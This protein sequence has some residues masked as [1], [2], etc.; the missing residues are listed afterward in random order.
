[1]TR[2]LVLLLAEIEET[3]NTVEFMDT[4]G[5]VLGFSGKALILTKG[6]ADRIRISSVLAG[7]GQGLDSHADTG[8]TMKSTGQALYAAD[9]LGIYGTVFFYC[10]DSEAPTWIR[11]GSGQWSSDGSVNLDFDVWPTNLKAVQL[12][13]ADRSTHKRLASSR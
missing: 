11:I 13:S 6:D 4:I 5:S 9:T 12:R 10:E 1:M 3:T 7:P 2:L 8:D